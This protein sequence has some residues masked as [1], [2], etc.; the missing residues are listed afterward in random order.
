MSSGDMD[1]FLA[2]L[3]GLACAVYGTIRNHQS[4][5]WQLAPEL[6]ADELLACLL[7]RAGTVM[8][9]QWKRREAQMRLQYGQSLFHKKEPTRVQF[10]V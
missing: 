3:F 6:P 9:Q 10:Q 2:P 1:T 8:L 4:P 7:L 5:H